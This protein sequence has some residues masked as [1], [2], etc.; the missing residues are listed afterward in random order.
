MHFLDSFY[1]CLALQSFATF[2]NDMNDQ[3]LITL[4]HFLV[5][6]ARE[7]DVRSPLGRIFRLGAM[8]GNYARQAFPDIINQNIRTNQ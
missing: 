4:Y 8:Y 3:A 2:I 7:V 1:S 5:L 6:L